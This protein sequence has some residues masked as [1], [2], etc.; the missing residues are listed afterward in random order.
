MRIRANPSANK[1]KR[2][3]FEKIAYFSRFPSVVAIGNDIGIGI[4]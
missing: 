1:K 3:S 2:K 4:E